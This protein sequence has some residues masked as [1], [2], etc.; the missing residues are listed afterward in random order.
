MPNRLQDNNNIN[1]CVTNNTNCF[2]I[3]QLYNFTKSRNIV[4]NI[5]TEAPSN[6][7]TTVVAN[8]QKKLNITFFTV[9]VS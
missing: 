2:S 8:S 1:S 4:A 5:K 3:V 9:N 6:N 7:T